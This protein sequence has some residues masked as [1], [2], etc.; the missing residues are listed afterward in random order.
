ASRRRARE[1]EPDASAPDAGA[2]DASV[3]TLAP[4]TPDASALTLGPETPDAS[5]RPPARADAT[6]ARDDVAP[7]RDRAPERAALAP[8]ARAAG[9]RTSAS[10]RRGVP[11][12][13][14]RA[15]PPDPA[16]ARP[17]Q[18][19]P[20]APAPPTD[21]AIRAARR[22]AFARLDELYIADAGL[23]IAWPFLPRYLARVGLVSPEHRF[24]D[25]AARAQAI[26]LVAAL[27]TGEPARP[28]WQLPLAKVLCGL[29]LDD[30]F[31]PPAPLPAEWL[32]EG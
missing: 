25:A 22:A 6:P 17:R 8:V 14:L 16:A 3:P 10:T 9:A 26:A 28:E 23:V 12:D 1:T 31:A 30:D 15:T 29:A 24:P 7:V 13:E 18:P 32:A 21:P 4:E 5:A 2:P 20:L 19:A 27:A 11:G